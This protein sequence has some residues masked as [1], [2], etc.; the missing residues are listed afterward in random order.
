MTPHVSHGGVGHRVPRTRLDLTAG[1]FLL[2]VEE[3]WARAPHAAAVGL[4]RP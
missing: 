4:L 3:E 2:E 1:G